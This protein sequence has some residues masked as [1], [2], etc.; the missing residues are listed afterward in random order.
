[1]Q[2]QQREL[3]DVSERVVSSST[4]KHCGQRR[5][6]DCRETARTAHGFGAR[7]ITAPPNSAVLR[8][9]RLTQVLYPDLA[10]KH[11][12]PRG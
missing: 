9:L 5:S 12:A 3:E 1:M 2:L 4:D 8:G 7:A 11:T 6:I 10:E